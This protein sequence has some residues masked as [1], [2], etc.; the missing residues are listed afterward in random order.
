MAGP[1]QGAG[2]KELGERAALA[3][4][5]RLVNRGPRRQGLCRWHCSELTAS[6]GARCA[7]RATACTASNISAASVCGDTHHRLSVACAR[8]SACL[9]PALVCG[10]HRLGSQHHLFCCGKGFIPRGCISLTDWLP[11]PQG[12]LE[13]QS[14]LFS[15]FKNM[16]LTLAATGLIRGTYV[17]RGSSA[18]SP[19]LSSPELQ[20]NAQRFSVRFCVSVFLCLLT[21]LR[22]VC[23]VTARADTAGDF[24]V[25]IP[26]LAKEALI[27]EPK[28]AAGV[29][30]PGDQVCVAR[31][32]G[33][34]SQ[35]LLPD[36]GRSPFLLVTFLSL[37][38]FTSIL[39]ALL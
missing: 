30:A 3:S 10:T 38:K 14:A 18:L 34:P 12:Q 7:A 33:V 37:Q 20:T 17:F 11:H 5:M 6:W 35:N 23:L 4:R 2:K 19:V 9:R 26:V 21:H 32:T 25:S 13:A 31:W 29:G 22:T 27:T 28:A 16:Q 15:T 1:P 36:R 8:L 39:P 24:Q